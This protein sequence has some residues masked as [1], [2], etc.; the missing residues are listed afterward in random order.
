MISEMKHRG[1]IAK[2]I[3][4]AVCSLIVFGIYSFTSR[5]K[6]GHEVVVEKGHNNYTVLD[7]YIPLRTGASWE[8]KGIKREIWEREVSTIDLTRDVKIMDIVPKN[9]GVAVLFNNLGFD[10]GVNDSTVY[11]EKYGVRDEWFIDGN[12]LSFG[13]LGSGALTLNFPLAVGQRMG[14]VWQLESRDDGYY[15][16]EVEEKVTREVFGKTYD[17]C[18][19]I[20][21]KT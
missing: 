16:W 3:F 21:Y 18:F 11:D 20:A 14:D 9:K 10:F 1:N 7:K 19:R 12:S 13:H 5:I 15:V 17:D 6:L 2:L 4:V 8:Y